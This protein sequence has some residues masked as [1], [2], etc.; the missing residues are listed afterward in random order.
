MFNP[1]PFIGPLLRYP[2]LFEVWFGLA[3]PRNRQPHTPARHAPHETAG[4]QSRQRPRQASRLASRWPA[5][6]PV[7][8]PHTRRTSARPCPRNPTQDARR[9]T[10]WSVTIWGHSVSA[11]TRA[12]V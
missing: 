3:M 6:E 2:Q 11:L 8:E 5:A 1:E 9:M 7:G 12:T 4:F 10:Q